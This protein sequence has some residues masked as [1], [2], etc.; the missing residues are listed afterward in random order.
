MRKLCAILAVLMVAACG[1]NGAAPMPAGLTTTG[2]LPAG[3]PTEGTRPPANGLP[4]A[5]GGVDARGGAPGGGPHRGHPSPGQR[6]AFGCRT[7]EGAAAAT[8]S[9]HRMD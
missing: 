9:P 6:A 7:V 4:A 5:P 1:R 2:A 8:G 3:V